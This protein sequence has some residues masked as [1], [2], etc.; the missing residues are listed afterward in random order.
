MPM[1]SEVGRPE[2]KFV[3][4]QSRQLLSS[5]G[6]VG[7]WK[8]AVLQA[9]QR[10][11]LGYGF[12]TEDHVFINRY[13]NFQSDRAENSWVGLYL[14]LGIAGVLALLS[15]LAFVLV[16]GARELLPAPAAPN[17]RLAA[18]AGVVVAGCVES[19]VQSF[20]YSAGDIA[21]LSLWV[22]A[23]LLVSAS[24]GKPASGVL[25]SHDLE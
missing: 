5:S 2:Y 7:A 4:S 24:T 20:I 21:T 10:P 18:C 15:L 3:A 17:L 22:C 23:A 9:D 16:R 12:G 19:L 6:R 1:A 25:L 14:Q 11:L 13:Y 8:G